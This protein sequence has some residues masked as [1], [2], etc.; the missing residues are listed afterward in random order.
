MSS[1]IPESKKTETT[2]RPNSAKG[3]DSFDIIVGGGLVNFFNKNVTPYPTDVGAPA[4]DL[5]PVT[6]QKDIMVNVARL[7]AQQEY[8]RIMDLVG[9]LQK[10][11]E[12]IRRRLEITDAVHAAVYQFQIFHGN[13]Y[14]LLFDKKV[15][16]T[17]LSMLG[18][19]DWFTGP[20]VEYE[21]ITRVK[22]LGDYSWIEVD[23][24]NQPV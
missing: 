21:Y 22:W 18:P 4:F 3:R 15:E 7:H 19:K 11:A 13:V 20:P 5:V 6:K 17:R 8:Q 23:E 9:V 16:C 12:Q 1:T 24:N 14:W 2:D 10:Q